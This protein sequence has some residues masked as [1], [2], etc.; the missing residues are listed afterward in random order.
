MAASSSTSGYGSYDVF[1][2]HRGPD[3]KK[4]FAGH[5]Y[6]RLRSLGLKVFLDQPELQRGDSLTSQI[7]SA[8]RSASVHVAVFSPGYADSNWCLDELLQMLKSGKPIIPV[9]Y[10]AKPS[11]LRWTR[12]SDGKYAQA[13][14]S[15]A[16]KTTD[17]DQPHQKRLRYDP[18]T[19]DSWRNALAS[20]SYICGFDLESC[21]GDEAELLDLVAEGVLKKVKK[22]TLH[23]AK[24]PTGLDEKI[25]H[26]ENEFLLQQQEQ[27][28]KPLVL[29][30]VGLGGIGKT[31]LAK[32]LFNRK[33]S[34]Y[35]RCCF[36]SD[37]RENAGKGTLIS[38]QKKLLK[39]LIGS[40][41]RID[42]IDEGMEKLKQHLSSFHALIVVDDVDH[43]D[44]IDSL[45]PD[46][47]VIPSDSLVLI[48]S[49]NK[50]ILTSSGIENSSIYKLTGLSKQH[51][52]ELFCFHA[53]KQPSPPS[54]FESLVN[55]FLKACGG[56]PLSLKVFG[57]LLCGK[58]KQSYW[59]EQLD[60]L[61]R[62]LHRDIKKSLQIS[63]DALDSE[64]REIFLDIA[65]FFIGEDRDMAVRIWDGCNWKGFENL[66]ERCL[67][68][69]DS[70]NVIHM[71]DHLRDLG[72]DITKA[73][74]LVRGTDNLDD[75]LQSSSVITKVR[76]IRTVQ[77]DRYYD[78]DENGLSEMTWHRGILQIPASEDGLLERILTRV[79]SPNLLWLRWYN[80]PYNY[81]PSWI[82][83]QNLRVLQVR[84]KEWTS[85]WEGELQ[86][87]LQLRDLETEGALWNFP[88][89]IGRLKYLERINI[90]AGAW[91]G[92]PYQ[93]KIL[94]LPE[95]FCQLQSLKTLRLT[96]CVEMKS[97]PDSFGDLR[98]L[99]RIELRYCENLER[100]PETFGNL[101][102]LK[103]LD[104][105]SCSKLTMSS[106]TLGNISRLEHINLFA[107]QEIEVLPLKI[108][109]QRSLKELNLS[110]TN[111]KELP[112]AI[113]ELSNLEDLCVGSPLL[114]TLP[115]SLGDLRNLKKLSLQYCPELKCLP[116]S[117]G[118]LTQLTLLEVQDCSISELPHSLGDLRNLKTLELRY[119]K[120]L[121]CL[122]ASVGRLTQLTELIV[123]GCSISELPH[124]LGDLRNL[125]TL[126]LCGLE[127]LKC[128][129]ASVG[130]LTQLTELR[131]EAPISEL[132][133]LRDL[134][135]LKILSLN[136][137]RE[138]EELPGLEHLRSL[139]QFSVSGVKL[140][141]VRGLAQCTKLHG[142]GRC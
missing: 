53:F 32:E 80:F 42:C 138:L 58:N 29:G 77:T 7:E 59:E 44:Q 141:K 20:V 112:N 31:T 50:D 119:C 46:Q 85:L 52:L 79:H 128:L 82:P 96:N 131:V 8:I 118:R 68:E 90:S 84:G 60:K 9:F 100:L 124:S 75:L 56:L 10:G 23:V 5:L 94:R 127:E 81:L 43:V 35:K 86:A 54:Q 51:S 116:V 102:K 69:V 78:E 33:S 115:S 133:W 19:I 25:E 104:L 64:E 134:R 97:L 91:D 34:Q 38:L 45:L 1:I 14:Q 6:R 136:G 132:P 122:P 76:G 24:Y 40:D 130:L 36:L 108:T 62:I 140:K 49:R 3:V 71:H 61:G 12:G 107:C 73:P 123:F 113:G 37:V 65:C 72:R 11:E 95:Q 4:T 63:V 129:P 2:S 93:H 30:I 120:E 139:Q 109:Q 26:F 57:A 18:G 89:S 70:D 55:K 66:E 106:E 47:T 111:L 114:D 27:S 17:D 21:N 39:D 103:Y 121:K 83:M 15:L 67:V 98:N 13:L 22:T 142:L 74:G 88:S 48:T 101:I 137:G 135:N 87:P 117:V 92:S 41:P 110:Y 126:K 99:Q 125:K 28:G 105:S 16:N